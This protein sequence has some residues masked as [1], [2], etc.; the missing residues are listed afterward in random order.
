MGGVIKCITGKYERDQELS[1][2]LFGGNASAEATEETG[3]AA[4]VPT[5]PSILTDLDE[6]VDIVQDK[7]V[8]EKKKDFTAA[9]KKYMGILM[10][11]LK[12]DGVEES[13]M[14]E[15]KKQLQQFAGEVM[16]KMERMDFYRTEGD[17]EA[18]GMLVM[19][20]R[21]EAGDESEN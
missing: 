1:D 10:K 7:T 14:D 9:L 21:N 6:A 16:K 18:E 11:K 13:K 8:K 15:K 2:S 5:K 17:Y 4:F 3:E 20:E 12:K 19:F